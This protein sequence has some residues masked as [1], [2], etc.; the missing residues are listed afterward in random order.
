MDASEIMW[1][2]V[3]RGERVRWRAKQAGNGP[4]KFRC[5]QSA[6]I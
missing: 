2:A 5:P 1:T 4:T 6:A 3:Q